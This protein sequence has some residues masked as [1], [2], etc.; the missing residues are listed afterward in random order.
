MSVALA[1]RN[2]PAELKNVFSSTA[3]QDYKWG[4][5]HN[6][7]YKIVPFGEIPL[8]NKIW[9]RNFPVGGN[10]RTLSVAIQT[11]QSKTYNSI[12]SP[13]FRFITD[14]NNTVFSLEVGQSDRILSPFYDNFVGKD[15][16]VKYTPRNPL[17]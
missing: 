14:L 17:L 4:V 15:K 7:Y 8:L 6:Q 12:A 11:H 3:H 16:Y 1:L 9:Q 2:L 10:S 5:I 13:A